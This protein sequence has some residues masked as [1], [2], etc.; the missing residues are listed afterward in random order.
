MVFGKSDGLDSHVLGHAGEFDHFLEHTLIAF[1]MVGDRPE[2]PALV[3]RGWQGRRDEQHELHRQASFDLWRIS[4]A[5]P[6]RCQTLKLLAVSSQP[7]A[8][9]ASDEL[10]N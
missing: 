7:S 8:I 9:R 6:G 10:K 2:P 3:Q 1:G 5:K 4:T